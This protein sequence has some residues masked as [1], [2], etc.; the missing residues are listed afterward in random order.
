MVSVKGVREKKRFETKRQLP[1]D[2]AS[3]NLLKMKR[4][5]ASGRRSKLSEYE[6]SSGLEDIGSEK[7]MEL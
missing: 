5:R 7:E 1:R 3:C 4:R 2:L 6:S